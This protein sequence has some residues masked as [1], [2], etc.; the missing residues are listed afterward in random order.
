[1]AEIL[2]SMIL[3]RSSRSRKILPTTG[4]IS[5]PSSFM[6][7]EAALVASTR[8]YS[9]DTL[10]LRY[11]VGNIAAYTPIVVDPS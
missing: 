3:A 7:L 9:L 10:L 1:M 11:V 6:L 5:T 8:E 4:S 2:R